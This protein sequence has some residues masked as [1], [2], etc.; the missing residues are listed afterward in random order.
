M[1]TSAA[2]AGS[3]AERRDLSYWMQRVLSELENVQSAP[4]TDAVH[5]LRVAIR[6]CRSAAEVVQEVDPDP[7]WAEMRKVPRK[8]FRE[9]GELR[10]TQVL[11]DWTKQLA[12]DTDL[13]RQQLLEFFAKKEAELR[14]DALKVAAKFDQKTWKKLDRTLRRRAR[15]LPLNSPAAEC[16]AV[17]RLEAARELHNKAVRSG[18]PE[19]WHALRIGIKK[20][21]YTVEIYLPQCYENWGGDLKKLQDILGEVHDL[22]VLSTTIAEQ[23]STE[24]Q[25]VRESWAQRITTE[26]NTRLDSYQ[27]QT[28]GKTSLWSTWRQQLPQDRRLD[29]AVLARVKI[30][31]RALDDNIQRSSRV[32]GL[33]MKLYDGMAKSKAAPIFSNRELRRIVRVAARMHGI[34]AGLDSKSP[35]K[36]ARS[37]LKKMAPPAGWAPDDWSL[38]G[39][40][41]RYHR[42]AEPKAKQKAYAALNELDQQR[43]RVGAGVLRLARGLRKCGVASPAWMRV[44]KSVDAL[45]VYV[46][47]LVDSEANAATLG[48]AKHLLET[49]VDCPIL[50]KPIAVPGKILQ[51]PAK[52]E[53]PQTVSSAAASD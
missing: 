32:A 29:A 21:R 50:L 25:E 31:A 37:F 5:D 2:L 49:I 33:A 52:N 28:L 38:L 3:K 24:F 45:I 44:E 30:T 7:A 40:M 35:Q 10:D 18:K 34:G 41:V 1:G 22:D 8:L 12:A 16:L 15:L 4:D 11:E 53:P 27:Q 9:L 23:T 6:R 43:V 46:P 17:E 19:A 26:R 51:L 20:F 48:A 47:G 42:G 14:V 39:L 13:I 36:A